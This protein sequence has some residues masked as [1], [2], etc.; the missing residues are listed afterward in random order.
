MA[1]PFTKLAYLGLQGGKSLM[2]L[3]HKEVSTRLLQW[4]APTAAP[5]TVPVPPEMLKQLRASMERLLEQDWREAEAGLYPASL[6]FDAP[7][8]DWATRY[9]L[10]WLD[11]P[12]TWNRRARRQVR[13]LPHDE[14]GRAH[15]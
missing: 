14:I 10:I 15:V 1:D 11:M 12:F 2:G 3:A 13:D 6:L 5:S 4:V 8:L 7:W 9:P